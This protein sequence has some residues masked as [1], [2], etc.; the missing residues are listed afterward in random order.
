[1]GEFVSRIPSNV[2]N[3]VSSLSRRVSCC[4]GERPKAEKEEQARQAGGRRLTKKNY[5][6]DE[7]PIGS[8]VDTLEK[9]QQEELKEKVKARKEV[10][11]GRHSAS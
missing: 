11:S 9:K 5:L 3:G 2:S 6:E 7:D 8:R 10:F 1:M 4:G